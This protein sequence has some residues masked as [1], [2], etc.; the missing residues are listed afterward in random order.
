MILQKKVLSRGDVVVCDFDHGGIG[1]E[2]MKRR[3]SVVISDNFVNQSGRM[4]VVVPLSTHRSDPKPRRNEV[5][6]PATESGLDCD[7]V[8]QPLQVRA[9][10]REVRCDAKPIGR[11]SPPLMAEISSLLADLLA[12]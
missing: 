7:G 4:I 9:V 10:D 11:V 5:L 12:L 1:A 6:I 8:A 3:P 2:Q